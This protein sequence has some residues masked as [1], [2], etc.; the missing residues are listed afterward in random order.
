MDI[1]NGICL[2]ETCHKEFHRK[3]GTMNNT[4]LQFYEHL[5]N[6]NIKREH[7]ENFYISKP[8]NVPTEINQRKFC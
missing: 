7:L 2:C 1:K 3:Y 5:N 4:R 6:K 8:R